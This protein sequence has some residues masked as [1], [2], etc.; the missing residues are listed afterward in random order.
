MKKQKY[1][2]KQKKLL[3]KFRSFGVK[4]FFTVMMVGFLMGLAFFARPKESMAENRVLTEFPP[5]TI[6]SFLD[7]SYFSQISLWFSDTFPGRD[8]LISLDR[9]L[10]KTY[11]IS[12]STRMIGGGV[13]DE[14][15]TFDEVETEAA[16]D[17]VPTEDMVVD[18]DVQFIGDPQ[19]QEGDPNEGAA[20]A[21]QA[22]EQS[23]EVHTEKQMDPEEAAELEA[24]IR[25]RIKQGMY[26]KN[27][28]AY[29]MYY[30]NQSA[31][32]IYTNALNNAAVKLSGMGNVYSI[33]V[34]DSSGVM[35][36]EEELQLL[37]GSD[38]ARAIS[39]YYSRLTN[40]TGIKTI[41][42]LREHNDEYLYF[43][44]D[45]HWTALGA[46]YV[47]RSFCK[48]KG[49][50]PHELS[51]FETMSFSPFLG[52]LYLELY[53]AEMAAN[54]D[55]VTAY[56][57][58]GTNEM[59][60]WNHDGEE[61]RWHIIEDVSTW[62]DSAGYY[63]FIGSDNPL[64][65]IHNPNI[66]DGSSCLVLK[67]SYGNCFVPFLVD[68]YQSIYVADFRYANINVIDYMHAHN[69]RDLI[70]INNITIIDSEQVSNAIAA[71][72]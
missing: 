52:S 10:K 5:F 11:G 71:K 36:S 64:S 48:A 65:I 9:T 14:I 50:T 1:S 27:G 55:T 35:L 66:T 42:T 7:G 53:D 12:T 33:L 60:I 44:S 46:Y 30:F 62:G 23:T 56:I 21:S 38:Q 67:E 41:E 40:A 4:A 72:L 2:K 32:D 47:Y 57:P 17:L 19:S 28:A 8:K 26:V 61:V 16:E 24:K 29:T 18:V 34:P 6:S 49:W 63:C 3:S 39:Y 58:N 13:G 59:T 20:S 54:P 69:I 37:G 31:A 22:L 43:K 45:H 51:D 70:V 25:E 15:P 68:H